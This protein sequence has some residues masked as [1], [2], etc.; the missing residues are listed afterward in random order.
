MFEARNAKDVE[1]D[2]AKHGYIKVGEMK[3]KELPPNTWNF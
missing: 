3:R 2:Q 1:E